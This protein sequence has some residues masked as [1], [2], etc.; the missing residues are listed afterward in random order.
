MD[1]KDLVKKTLVLG[2]KYGTLTLNIVKNGLN[3]DEITARNIL[4]FMVA[5][6]YLIDF[7]YDGDDMNLLC[8]NAIGDLFEDKNNRKNTFEELCKLY[9]GI[10]INEEIK[11]TNNIDT[12]P[13]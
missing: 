4:D 8:F 5:K 12:I 1:R 9:D 2:I 13:L 6:D 7:D 3:I 10:E 11:P